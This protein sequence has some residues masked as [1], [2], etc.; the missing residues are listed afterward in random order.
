VLVRLQFWWTLKMAN[1]Q[2]QLASLKIC[3]L[4]DENGTEIF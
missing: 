2:E 4:Q 1:L 3:F